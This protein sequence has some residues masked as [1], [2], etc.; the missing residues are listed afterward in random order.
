MTGRRAIAT[1]ARHIKIKSFTIDGEV[2]LRGPTAYR[3]STNCADGRLA[4][5]AILY[6]FGLI[7][8]DGKHMRN[9]PFLDRKA[10]LARLLRNTE[11]GVLFNEHIAEDGPCRP[12]GLVPRA[13]CRRRSMAQPRLVKVRNPTAPRCSGRRARCGTDEPD[14][15]RTR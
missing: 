6:A 1:A 4:D 8:R 14:E 7:E 13:L 11:A 15:A 9:R 5:T 3:C 12:A 10:T 2:V